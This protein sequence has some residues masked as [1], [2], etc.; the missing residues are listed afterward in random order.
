MESLAHTKSALEYLLRAARLCKTRPHFSGSAGRSGARVHGA[1]PGNQRA[2]SR[3]IPAPTAFSR[4]AMP[5]LRL[6]AHASIQWNLYS[7]IAS[8]PVPFISRHESPLW[9][10]CRLRF[11]GRRP[12]AR[13]PSRCD[14]SV[15]THATHFTAGVSRDSAPRYGRRRAPRKVTRVPNA[16]LCGL[17]L[18]EGI[19]SNLAFHRPQVERAVIL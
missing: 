16:H 5:I 8:G 3:R 15:T 7:P 9:L 14:Q 17:A 6:R 2:A 1:R 10:G 11:L 18:L 13:R 4:G 19:L 12:T